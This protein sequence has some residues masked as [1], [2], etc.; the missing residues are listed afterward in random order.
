M[1]IL[2]IKYINFAFIQFSLLIFNFVQS[3]PLVSFCQNLV[4]KYLLNDVDLYWKKLKV[5][6]AILTKINGRTKLNG[7][8]VRWLNWILD[9]IEGTICDL[10]NFNRNLKLRPFNKQMWASCF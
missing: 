9:K 6:G 10:A 5:N 4:I 8:K 2:K 1:R 7:S 3:N